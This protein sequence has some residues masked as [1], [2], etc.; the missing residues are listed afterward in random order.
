MKNTYFAAI[1]FLLMIWSNFSYAQKK[2]RGKLVLFTGD[3]LTGLFYDWRTKANPDSVKIIREKDKKVLL[4]APNQLEAIMLEDADV[5]ITARMKVDMFYSTRR[6]PL[7]TY[8]RVNQ[9]SVR[10]LLIHEL[11]TGKLSLYLY[12]DENHKEHFYTSPGKKEF[13]E[14]VYKQVP[15]KSGEES[16]AV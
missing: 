6:R 4:F 9:I 2:V 16:H 12:T 5:Y 13:T 14:L 10:T 15:S 7:E 8:A 1:L 3:T 11:V